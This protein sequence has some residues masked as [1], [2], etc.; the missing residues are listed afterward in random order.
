[1]LFLC[2]LMRTTSSFEFHSFTVK[3]HSINS[4]SIRF[5]INRYRLMMS[6]LLI[7]ESESRLDY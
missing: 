2:N 3:N 5:I 1:M 4:H 7:I 6:Y